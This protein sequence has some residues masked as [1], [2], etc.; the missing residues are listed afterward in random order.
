MHNR[1]RRIIQEGRNKLDQQEILNRTILL[2]SASLE[3]RSKYA[4]L[5]EIYLFLAYKPIEYPLASHFLQI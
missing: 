2:I 5:L 4:S 3:I 1:N